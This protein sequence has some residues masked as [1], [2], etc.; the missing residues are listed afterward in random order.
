MQACSVTHN[1]VQY[2][3][4]HRRELNFKSVLDDNYT[5]ALPP[6]MLM[7]I[8]YAHTTAE[9]IVNFCFNP[10]FHLYEDFAKYFNLYWRRRWADLEWPYGT[11]HM[12]VGHHAGN[13]RYINYLGS[14]HGGANTHQSMFLQSLWLDLRDC[15]RQIIEPLSFRDPTPNWCTLDID[16]PYTYSTFIYH[17]FR[18]LCTCSYCRQ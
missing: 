16:K 14:H 6:Q 17:E 10:S 9:T 8:L 12:T 4:S 3:F 2:V 5:I 1:A 18:T 7:Q 11:C 13:L 15:I